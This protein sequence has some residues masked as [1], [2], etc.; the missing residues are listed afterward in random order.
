MANFKDLPTGLSVG[1]D[2]NNIVLFRDGHR[3]KIDREQFLALMDYGKRCF[4]L[5]PKP[6]FWST[7]KNL[8]PNQIAALEREI[9]AND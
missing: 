6:G 8:D 9:S 5:V 3:I 4:D 7:P 2:D 1:A